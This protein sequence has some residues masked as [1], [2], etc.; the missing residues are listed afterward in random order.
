MAKAK[1]SPP[2]AHVEACIDA[3]VALH[4]KQEQVEA[5]YK[6]GL[7]ELAD[8]DGE[9]RVPVAYLAERLGVERKTVYRHIGRSMT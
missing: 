7:A 3:V 8:Q 9:F 4:R 1:Y 6:R 2:N 5:E